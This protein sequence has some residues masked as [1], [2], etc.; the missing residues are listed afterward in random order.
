[1]PKLVTAEVCAVHDRILNT[2]IYCSEHNGNVSP[3][4]YTFLIKVILTCFSE[5][6][7]SEC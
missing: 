5:I 3:K 1:M 4:D 6:Y 7:I 2:Y